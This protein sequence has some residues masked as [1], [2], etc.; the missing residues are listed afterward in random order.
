MRG[1][2]G[3][4]SVLVC[5][6][7]V[8]YVWANYTAAVSHSGTKATDQAT[9]LSGH[10]A[11]GKSALESIKTKP[12]LDASGRLKSLLVTECKADG[13]ME[14]FYGFK[15]GDK[16]ISEG[17]YDLAMNPDADTASAMLLDAYEKSAS[18]EVIRDGKQIKL[19]LDGAGKNIQDQFN[20]LQHVGG[21]R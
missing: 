12:D 11:D 19:P 2:L 10:G 20:Q 13:A 6:V 17:Q 5:G 14:K 4:V 16:I 9:Q 1:A 8:A 21:S 15:K 3:L 18:V 7:I